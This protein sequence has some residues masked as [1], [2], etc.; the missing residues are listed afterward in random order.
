MGICRGSFDFMWFLPWVLAPLTCDSQWHL[1]PKS[2]IPLNL[3]PT[4]LNE[5]QPQN[6]DQTLPINQPWQL[7]PKSDP[8]TLPGARG[9]HPTLGGNPLETTTFGSKWI[10]WRQCLESINQ[11]FHM[12]DSLQLQGQPQCDV[13][14]QLRTCLCPSPA[15]R[16]KTL[17]YTYDSKYHLWRTYKVSG[18][19]LDL[20]HTFVTQLSPLYTTLWWS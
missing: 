6:T 3:M 9:H 12:R 11:S 2:E 8:I 7:R 17:K 1:T 19:P 18:V 4:V 10:L 16:V 14:L 15:H 5:D 13:L 20:L